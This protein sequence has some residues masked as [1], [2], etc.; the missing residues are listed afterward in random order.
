MGYAVRQSNSEA[1]QLLSDPFLTKKQLFPIPSLAMIEGPP[2]RPWN[3]PSTAS[4]KPQ[5]PLEEEHLL[6]HL[7]GRT[8]F[9]A[10]E[11]KRK[12][13][14]PMKF[15]FSQ[16]KLFGAEGKTSDEEAESSSSWWKTNGEGKFPTSQFDAIT[17][18]IGLREQVKECTAMQRKRPSA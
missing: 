11:E 12:A 16:W 3:R 13:S 7:L 9:I 15:G 2:P 5:G 10:P 18:C 14:E 6:P 4:L 17:S 8:S 1:T